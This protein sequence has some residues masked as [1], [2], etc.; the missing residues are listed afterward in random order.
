M[1]TTNFLYSEILELEISGYWRHFLCLA[2]LGLESWQ[3]LTNIETE[4]VADT[5]KIVYIEYRDS[6]IS[7]YW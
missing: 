2:I 4:E 7:K 3:I 1:N 6:E 5:E